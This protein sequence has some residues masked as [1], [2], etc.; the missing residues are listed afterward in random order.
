MKKTIMNDNED[1]KNNG[2]PTKNTTNEEHTATKRAQIIVEDVTEEELAT[3]ESIPARHNHNTR[4][5]SRTYLH[6]HKD[7]VF[8][9]QGKQIPNK[10]TFTNNGFTLVPPH[11]NTTNNIHN[12]MMAT[13]A[14]F[15]QLSTKA[16]VKEYGQAEVAAI[17]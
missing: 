9:M 14:Y 11:Q 10:D 4:N 7:H 2:T 15:A 8:N 3:E 5:N 12:H 1:D 16:T 17:L 13:K 6:L